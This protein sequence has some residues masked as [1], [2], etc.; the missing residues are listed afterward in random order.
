M[1]HWTSSRAP[2]AAG[3]VSLLFLPGCSPDRS[4][5]ERVRVYSP[6]GRDLMT[7]I[8]SE[9]ERSYPELDVQTLDMGSQ[10]VYDRLRSERANPQADVWFGGPDAIFER[11][12]RDGLLVPHRPGWAEAI[13]EENRDPEGRYFGVYRT[14]PVLVYVTSR[15]T[16]DE[17]PR[18]WS[19]LEDP[20]WRGRLLL[21][22]PLASGVMRTVFAYLVAE[23]VGRGGSEEEGLARLARLDAQVKEYVANPALL[24]EKLLRGE[25]D[26]TFWE[27][28]DV[29]LQRARG[30][31][32]GYV[33]PASGTPVIDD[34]V[35]IVAG[36][37]NPEGARRF[38]EFVGSEAAVALACERAFRLPARQD[39]E[40]GQLPDWARNL[41]AELR[42]ARY[43]E[44]LAAREGSR[45]LGRWDREIRGQ[46]SRFRPPAGS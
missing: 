3:L 29:L 42:P 5:R 30:A 46:G 32:L 12:A 34:S 36:G 38:V 15:L 37:P 24:F 45:W 40:V 23:T 31:P 43:D 2:I 35:G 18:D 44:L 33:L 20:R 17:A 4:G 19:D 10:E 14:V 25:G 41:L 39:L 21:R 27:L 11:A 13:P 28:T 22:D 8:E 26:V 6:H 16:P 1:T 7:L 9:F